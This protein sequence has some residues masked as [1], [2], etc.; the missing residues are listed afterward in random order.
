MAEIKRIVENGYCFVLVKRERNTY[1][2]FRLDFE[3]KPVYGPKVEQ[4]CF[5]GHQG[6]ALSAVIKLNQKH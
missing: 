3:H 4:P 5:K 2:Y 1:N 6:Y